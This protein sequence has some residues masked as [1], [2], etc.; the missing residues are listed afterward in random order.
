[1]RVQRPREIY[2]TSGMGRKGKMMSKLNR[3]FEM[4]PRKLNNVDFKKK[5]LFITSTKIIKNNEMRQ[6][7]AKQ[8]AKIK[9]EQKGVYK[10][11][12]A[13]K[14]MKF[15]DYKPVLDKPLFKVDKYLKG[16]S[17]IE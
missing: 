1:V 4:A 8:L 2:A 9:I 14:D 3:S 13:L 7:L 12:M 11:P 17:L 10:T 6:I 16:P 5:P 15:R